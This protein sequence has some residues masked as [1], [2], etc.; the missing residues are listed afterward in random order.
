MIAEL[1]LNDNGIFV[2][3][4]CGVGQA[5][6]QVASGSLVKRS[7]GIELAEFQSKFACDG[8][9]FFQE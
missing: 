5:V 6:V 8:N 7:V 3:P 4:G 9:K 2:D 1:E